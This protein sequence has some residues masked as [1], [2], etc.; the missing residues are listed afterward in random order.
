MALA[1][2][3][4][5]RLL[6]TEI[7]FL[8][9]VGASVGLLNQPLTRVRRIWLQAMW[10][11]ILPLACLATDPFLF[12]ASQDIQRLGELR[13]NPFVAGVYGFVGW[14]ML[15]LIANWILT[16]NYPKSAAILSG[17]LL[18]GSIFAGTVALVLTPV[19][20]LSMIFIIGLPGITPWLTML[21][22]KKASTAC[23]ETA[24]GKEQKAK[25]VLLAILGFAIAVAAAIGTVVCWIVI[26]GPQ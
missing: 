8:T 5:L 22:Y 11:I 13:L 20:L 26:R 15:M 6:G 19:T 25:C 21:V 14:Q 4:Q 24:R 1:L 16:S 12:I 10:G 2:V 23:W 3:A 18:A 7:L 9:A 17:G